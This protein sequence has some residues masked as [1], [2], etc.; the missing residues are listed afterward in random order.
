MVPNVQGVNPYFNFD[1]WANQSP[2]PHESEAVEVTVFMPNGML[3]ILNI[4]RTATLADLKEVI[5]F[6][7]F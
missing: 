3:I 7:L 6:S 1:F 2:T 5:F 4:S